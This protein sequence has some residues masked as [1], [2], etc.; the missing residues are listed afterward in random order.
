LRVG[1][2]TE[3]YPPNVKG[4][5]EVSVSLLARG[6]KSRGLDVR[7]LSFDGEGE[8]V[9]DG[10]PVRRLKA[11]ESVH[12]AI[13]KSNLLAYPDIKEFSKDR[14]LIHGYNMKYYPAT[15]RA[16]SALG[17]PSVLTMTTY[18]FY[19]PHHVEGLEDPDSFLGKLHQRITDGT[20]RG[21]IGRGASALVVL[22]SAQKKIYEEAG[23]P[24][25]KL[26]VIPN[27]VDPYFLEKGRDGPG[28]GSQTVLYVGRLSPE[29][30]LETLIKAYTLERSLHPELKLLLVG[31]GPSAA[32]LK[33]LAGELGVLEGVEFLGKL[34]YHEIRDIYRKAS[35]Y[36]HPALW[37]EPFGR[38]VLEAMASALPVIAS[39]TGSAPELLAQAG[40]FFEPGNSEE[41][42]SRI[43]ELLR[44]G[45][46]ARRLSQVARER[47]ISEYSPERILDRLVSLYGES[48]DAFPSRRR[49]GITAEVEGSSMRRA[50]R[51]EEGR[52]SQPPLLREGRVR[53]L[54]HRCGR[55][56]DATV[57]PLCGKKVGLYFRFFRGA[58]KPLEQPSPRILVMMFTRGIGDA[59]LVTPALNALR[60]K[61]PGAFIAVVGTPYVKELASRFKAVDHFIPFPVEHAT[62][63][64]TY[65]LV[66]K[67][68]SLRF[69]AVIDILADRSVLSALISFL[70]GARNVVGFAAGLRSIFFSHRYRGDLCGIHFADL[71]RRMVAESGLGVSEWCGFE[72]GFSSTREEA[73]AASRLSGMKRPLVCIHPGTKTVKE[74]RWPPDNW[75]KLISHLEEKHGCG[76]VLIGHGAERALC[77]YIEERTGRDVLNL[78]G[79]CTIGETAA[80]IRKSD[81]LLCVPSGPL[82]MGVAMGVPVVYIGGGTDLVRWRAYGGSVIHRAV[83]QSDTC[84]PEDCRLCEQ[85]TGACSLGI[86]PDAFLQAAEE[87][88]EKSD[89]TK[90]MKR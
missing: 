70:S 85:R 16:S 12:F 61:H 66:R 43:E 35:I 51:K 9:E 76:I 50:A 69:D 83:L 11:A 5:G 58:R 63:S 15:V 37:P 33:S 39:R 68:R 62:L 21:M 6:L 20:V 80:V 86:A 42:A 10:V 54:R 24:E 34:P 53:R 17:L 7:V 22:S 14:D 1:I 19:Y 90:W 46:L 71:V 44:D 31:T 38:S 81:L 18:G 45:D 32:A 23:F 47:A 75:V 64:A 55:L 30:G 48:K 49:S 25:S 89:M 29:K 40:L 88:G 56:L 84:R 57:V 65:Y 67:L 72:S 8:K 3:R 79:E 13:E 77:N 73:S 59:V 60:R 27:F 2:V 82:H 36:V 78:S 74:F 4:G 52:H 26:C 28:L 87:I 41:I